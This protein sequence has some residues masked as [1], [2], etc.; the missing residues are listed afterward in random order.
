MRSIGGSAA[1]FQA[2]GPQGRSC[3]PAGAGIRADPYYGKN[4]FSK[5]SLCQPDFPGSGCKPLLGR[6]LVC[7]GNRRENDF[8]LN[9][10]GGILPKSGY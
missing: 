10:L 9:N 5:S 1:S 7:R 2:N 4:I 6:G 8:R 3:G